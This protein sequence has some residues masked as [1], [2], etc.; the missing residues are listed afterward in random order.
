[1]EKETNPKKKRN[2]ILFFFLMVIAMLLFDIIMNE[3]Y[4]IISRMII[5][6]K[7]GRNI[8]IEAVCAFIILIVLLLFKNSYIFSEKKKGFLYSL[9]VGGY[10]TV[11]ATFLLS[12]SISEISGSINL[13]DVGS[14]AL[15]CL[16]IGIYEEFLCRG[17][18]QNEFIE[19]F[20]NT[21]KEIILS[22]LES[23]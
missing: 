1:M 7:Y 10:I 17:W 19:R 3:L 22:I 23:L 18:I 12:G 6:G 11:M 16:L 4:P 13:T 21:R 15:F 14:L 2:I 5:Y 8:I 20:A 9:L